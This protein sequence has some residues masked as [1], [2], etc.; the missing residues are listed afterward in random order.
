M[1]IKYSTEHILFRSENDIFETVVV[2]IKVKDFELI[3]YYSFYKLPGPCQVQVMQMTYN[4]K[5]Y[6][7]FYSCDFVFDDDEDN[8]FHVKMLDFGFVYKNIRI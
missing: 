3:N 2:G 8:V 1:P 5:H 7:T 4:F 6:R